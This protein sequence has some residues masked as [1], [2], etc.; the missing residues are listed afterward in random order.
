MVALL[1]TCLRESPAIVSVLALGG[2]SVYPMG[3][4]M[5]ENCVG[6]RACVMPE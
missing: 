5:Q 1:L 2:Q 4:G 3:D 6:L